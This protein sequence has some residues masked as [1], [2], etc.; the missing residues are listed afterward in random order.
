MNIKQVLY[1]AVALL[2]TQA[3]LKAQPTNAESSTQAQLQQLVHQVQAK[4]QAGKHDEA[5]YADELKTLDSMIASKKDA[6]T[7]EAVQFTYMKG[8]LYLEV[9]RNY[10]KGGE[11]MQQIIKNYPNTPYSESA[12]KVVA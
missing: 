4:A 9:M 11:I 2:F 3:G 12:A 8:M 6:K 5:D 10:D 7:D 1:L